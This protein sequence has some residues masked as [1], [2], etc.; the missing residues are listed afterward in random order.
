MIIVLFGQP[1]SGKSTIANEILK[2]TT[3]YVNIDGDKLR[4]LFVNKD[5][6]KEGRIKNLNRASDIAHYLNSTGKN[7]ILSLV[8]PYKEARDYLRSLNND[9]CW[10]HL[11]YKGERGRESYHVKDFEPPLDEN[12]LQIDTS[13]L[14]LES[15]LQTINSYV[16]AKRF[17]KSFEQIWTMGNVYWKM[18]TLA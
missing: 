18:A 4:E 6:S 12:V 17:S 8:Y 5:Y 13:S 15:C 2:Q 10:V 9:V 7:V 1:H 11:T 16:N 3:T 14:S